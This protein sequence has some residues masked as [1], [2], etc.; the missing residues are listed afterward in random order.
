MQ[1]KDKGKKKKK[2]KRNKGLSGTTQFTQNPVQW[3]R[4]RETK[5]NP[6]NTALKTAVEVVAA[7]G[8][9]AYLSAAC[10]KYATIIGSVLVA[11]GNYSDDTGLV[12]ALGLGMVGNGIGK[13]KE[14]SEN[15]DQTVQQRIAAVKDDLGYAFLIKKYSVKPTTVSGIEPSKIPVPKT[16]EKS[17]PKKENEPDEFPDFSTDEMLSALSGLKPL[18]NPLMNDPANDLGNTERDPN[19]DSQFF[20]L[21]E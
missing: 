5:S 3:Y 1:P 8:V 2:D 20:N 15:P 18:N 9:G 14:Y 13:A 21:L 4:E 16:T 11:V 7:G 6:G 10:G 19:D 12:K 17:L